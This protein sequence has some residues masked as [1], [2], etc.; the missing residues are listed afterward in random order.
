MKTMLTSAALA[1]A[2]LVAPIS[3]THA[4]APTWS[5]EQTGVWQVVSQS[6]A[7]EVAKNGKWPEAYAAD[8][9]V[10]WEADWPMPRYKDSLTKWSRFND[11]QRK[12]LQYEIAPAAI[13]ISG[14][15]AVVN[16]T[17]VQISQRGDEKPDRDVIGITETLVRSGGTWKF[18]ATSGFDLKH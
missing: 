8:Q 2:F 13:T 9:M 3:M 12:T 17:A 18:L 1:A 4:Q 14:D 16:Y 11:S 7:D 15:T 5:K 6:W 10:S